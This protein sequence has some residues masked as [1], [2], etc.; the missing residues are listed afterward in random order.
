MHR[1]AAASHAIAK[2]G[3]LFVFPNSLSFQRPRRDRAAQGG[4]PRDASG[5]DVRRRNACRCPAGPASARAFAWDVR[6]SPPRSRGGRR[7][8]GRA[9]RCGARSGGMHRAGR[10]RVLAQGRARSARGARQAARILT[11]KVATCLS[12]FQRIF[13][14]EGVAP[15]LGYFFAGRRSALHPSPPLPPHTLLTAPRNQP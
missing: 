7:G 14:E 5:V 1:R 4:A 2:G 9:P 11:E 12:H 6:T 13:A 3:T 8:G 15:T 10:R